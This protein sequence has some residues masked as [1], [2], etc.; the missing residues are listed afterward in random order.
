MVVF[1]CNKTIMFRTRVPRAAVRYE[2]PR[3]A[4]DVQLSSVG[5]PSILA[6]EIL[7]GTALYAQFPPMDSETEEE[8]QAQNELAIRGR[9]LGDSAVTALFRFSL[10]MLCIALE[11]DS[12]FEVLK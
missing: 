3:P 10:F 4:P 1:F 7:R 9:F 6:V 5:R 12:S 11:C 2:P 8:K